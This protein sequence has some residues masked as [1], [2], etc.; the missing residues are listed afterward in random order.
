MTIAL[1]STLLAFLIGGSLAWLV[2]RTDMPGRKIVNPLAVLPYIMPSW[3]IAQAWLVLFKNQAI[4]RNS[5]YYLRPLWDKPLRIG[6]LTVLYQL[7]FAVHCITTLSFSLFVS[8][9]LMSIDSSLEE[10]GDLMGASRWRIL[11]KITF[12]LVLPALLSGLIMTFSKVMGTFGG[13]NILG[14]PIRYYVVATMLSGSIAAG[15]KA[16]AFVLAIVLILFAMVTISFNQKLVGTRKSYETIG[17]RGFV[18]QVSKLG[19][20]QKVFFAGVMRFSNPGYRSS[21]RSC[22]SFH[23]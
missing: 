13:P 1:G 18:A 9:A 2:V 15:D 8:A 3:T 17:G 20:M 7:S 22:F 5:G 19:R 21:G 23:R 6:F 10:A 12:P 4:R 11:R 16:D 14:S